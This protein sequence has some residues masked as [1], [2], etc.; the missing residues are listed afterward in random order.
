MWIPNP[1]VV[2]GRIGSLELFA[3]KKLPVEAHL[4]WVAQGLPMCGLPNYNRLLCKSRCIRT[5]QTTCSNFEYKPNAIFSAQQD[6]SYAKKLS[7]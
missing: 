4:L 2:G 7:D 3:F 6:P 5:N 1:L